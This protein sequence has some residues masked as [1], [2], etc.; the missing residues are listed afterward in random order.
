MKLLPDAIVHRMLVSFLLFFFFL[1]GRVGV[2]RC[3]GWGKFN[4]FL[5]KK[6]I[7]CRHIQDHDMY[8]AG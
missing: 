2:K 3:S 7:V 6:I 5:Y 4:L 1:P 8:C